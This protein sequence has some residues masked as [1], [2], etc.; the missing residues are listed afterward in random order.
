MGEIADM[1]LD[2]TLCEACGVY[3]DSPAPG[4]PRYCSRVCAAD[5]SPVATGGNPPRSPAEQARR[6]EKNRRKR[7]RRKARKAS[8]GVAA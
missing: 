1:M 8:Q 5:R 3:I 7:Q 6:R 2:G 4:H